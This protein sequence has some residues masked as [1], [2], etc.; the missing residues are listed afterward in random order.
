MGA[1]YDNIA[2]IQHKVSK[3]YDNINGVW[4]PVKKRYVKVGE[5]WQQ[6]FMSAIEWTHTII[7]SDAVGVSDHNHDYSLYL[8]TGTTYAG[9]FAVQY[10]FL[11]LLVL[12]PGSTI[13]YIFQELYSGRGFGA[14]I[15]INDQLV[16]SGYASYSDSF[17]GA[18]SYSSGATINSIKPMISSGGSG[19]IAATVTVN[20]AGGKPFLLTFKDSSDL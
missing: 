5:V 16:N 10:N 2:G 8:F 3:R 19:E 14:K 4:R 18:L 7:P 11:E 20:P 6:S 15:Y 17:S 13:N 9:S 12:P 1:R